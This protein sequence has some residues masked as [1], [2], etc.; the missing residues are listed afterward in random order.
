M[1]KKIKL[2]ESSAQQSINRLF[3]ASNFSTNAID[4]EAN[5]AGMYTDL[6]SFTNFFDA[7]VKIKD[8]LVRLSC[9]VQGDAGALNLCLKHMFNTD[10]DTSA[11][12]IY[13][14]ATEY[15]SRKDFDID[16]IRMMS[17]FARGVFVAKSL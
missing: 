16:A 17:S 14:N 4:Y 10:N 11:Y 5:V 12:F 9:M 15:R 3:E 2:N 6:K 8:A 13:E 1:S 7:H